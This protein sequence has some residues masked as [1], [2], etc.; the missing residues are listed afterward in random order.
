ME[1][2]S[3][4][5]KEPRSH[6]R[7]N[8]GRVGPEIEK[9]IVRMRESH[10]EWGRRRIADGLAKENNWVPL[11]QPPNGKTGTTRCR[12]LA[13]SRGFGKKGGP[14]VVARCADEPGQALNIDLCFVPSTHEQV[15]L[16]RHCTKIVK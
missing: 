7:K 4:G 11:S 2:G 12:T 5:L 9:K 14:K 15:A 13:Q 1:E 3:E 6:A 16:G 10:P 8:R